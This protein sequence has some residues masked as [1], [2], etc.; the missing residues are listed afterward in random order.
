MNTAVVYLVPAGSGIYELYSEPSEL[1]PSSGPLPASAGFWSRQIHRLHEQ[2][3]QSAH[4]AHAA[5]SSD[6]S[7]QSDGSLTRTRHWIVRRIAES[8]TEQRTLWSLRGASSASFVYPADLSADSAAAVRV[9]LLAHARR[10][11]GW[12]LL[13]NLAAAAVTAILA[14]LP[15]PNLIG[16]YFAFRVVGHYLSWRGAYQALE[17]V[18]WQAHAEPLL[19]ELGRLAHLSRDDRAAQVA[20]VAAGLHLPRLAA[21]FES[22]ATPPR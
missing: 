9:R 11:H 16:Y 22:V 13:L 18:S 5:R 17:R 3:R 6:G 2:W 21:F 1:V 10:H 19:A 7:G 8:I 4:A 15:G 12:W 20:H 14:L